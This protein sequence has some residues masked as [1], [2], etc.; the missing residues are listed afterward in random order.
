VLEPVRRNVAGLFGAVVL[1]TDAWLNLARARSLLRRCAAEGRNVRLRMPVVIYDPQ[2][3]AFGDFVDIGENVILR[4]GG[5][6]SIGNRVLIA[7]GAAVVTVGHP[8]APP[9][10][11]QIKAAPVAIGDDVW[12]GANAVILPGVS[13]GNGAIVAAGAVVT[14]DVAPYTIVAG[15]PAKLQRPIEVSV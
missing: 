5:G 8:I 10:W 11:G 9:R 15:V 6:L 1:R 4:A 14:D 2:K 12:I 3:L 13:V 7:A